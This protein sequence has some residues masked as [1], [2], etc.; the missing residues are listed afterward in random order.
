YGPRPSAT[1]A[2]AFV[3]GLYRATLLRPGSTAEV[4]FYVGQLQA[5]T[6]SRSQAASNFYNSPEN[7]GNQVRFFYRYFLGRE[8]AP[9]EVDY[10][11]QR[12]Q[13]GTDE[14]VVMANFVLSPEYTGRND[15]TQFTL[16][17]YYA[18]LGRGAAPGE[19]GYYVGRLQ[20]GVGTRAGILQNFLRSPEGIGRVVRGDYLAYLGRPAAAGESAFWQ[21]QVQGGATFGSVA[22]ALLGSAEFSANA[23]LT[24]TAAPSADA[25][26]AR[27]VDEG[28]ALSFTGAG[29]GS[30]PLSY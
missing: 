30:G 28:G 17:M 25:G 14:G 11:T 9:F 2:E 22:V 16:T 7:R 20:T 18:I 29:T 23:G 6:L 4:A 10:Y 26:P 27:A 8:A 24:V 21:N 12:L 5:G 19:V 15:D 1:Q 13:S 3:K